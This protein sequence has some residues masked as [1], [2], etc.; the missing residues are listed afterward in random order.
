V[1]GENVSPA[2]TVDGD[3]DGVGATVVVTFCVGAVVTTEDVGNVVFC[4]G[5]ALVVV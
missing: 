5:T 1:G 3:G 2:G 4:D